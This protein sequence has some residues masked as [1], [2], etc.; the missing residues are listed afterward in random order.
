VLDVSPFPRTCPGGAECVVSAD[1]TLTRG[2]VLLSRPAA[3]GSDSP[4]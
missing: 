3:P 1:E 4:L 2:R